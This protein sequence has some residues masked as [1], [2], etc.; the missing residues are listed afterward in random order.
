MPV[1]RRRQREAGRKA[2]EVSHHVMTHRKLWMR[3]E[4]LHGILTQRNTINQ[5]A[6]GQPP[7][8]YPR[9]CAS[10][11]GCLLRRGGAMLL[12]GR[13]VPLMKSHA[14]FVPK[15]RRSIS[16]SVAD[17][18][19]RGDEGARGLMGGAVTSGVRGCSS[20]RGRVTDVV[21]FHVAG[22][23]L[24][25]VRLGIDININATAW[26]RGRRGAGGSG[27]HGWA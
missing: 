2:A 17:L 7:I 3:L 15:G 6:S 24:G 11:R 1:E 27:E 12:E 18:V 9:S 22:G 16:G 19:G 4:G 5:V 25:V 23:A 26:R 20:G 14:A 8:R 21:V 10:H 13:Q